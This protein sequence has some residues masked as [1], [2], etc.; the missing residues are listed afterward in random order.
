[1]KFFSSSSLDNSFSNN[2]ADA[3]KALPNPDPSNYEIEKH[4]GIRNFTIV[5][6]KYHDCLNYE[7]RKILVFK[8]CAIEDL[9]KQ[10]LI[11]PHF[12]ENTNYHSPIARF[13]PTENGWTMA[14]TLTATISK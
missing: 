1:M 10:D 13:E 4:I 7:G 14:V 3:Y 6:L 12:S 11:D 8:D 9:I 2:Q 5:Q